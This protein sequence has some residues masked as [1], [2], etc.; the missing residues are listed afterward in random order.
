MYKV[1]FV[2]TISLT[3]K[4][5]VLELAKAMYKTGEFE[6]HFV[7]DYDAEFEKSLPEYIHYRPISMKRGVSL[8]GIKAVCEMIKYFK[9]EKFD[10]VQYST[11]NASCYASLAA[12]IAGIP[13]RLY[14]QWGIVYVGFKGIK[15]K[16]FKLIEKIVCRNSTMIEPDSFGNLHY[17]YKEGLYDESKS[18]VIWNGSACGVDLKK[19]DIS[20]KSEWNQKIREKFSIPQDAVV[21]V[22]VGRITRD[23]GINELFEATKKLMSQKSD[24]YLLL[25]GNMDKSETVDCNLYQWSQ[26]EARVIYCGYTKEVQEYLSAG[27]VYV[28]PSYRE[29]FGMAVIEAESMGVP[30]IVTDIPGVTDAMKKDCTGLVVKKGDSFALYEAMARLYTCKDMRIDMGK[31]AYEFA[32]KNFEQSKL[33]ESIIENRLMLLK[34]KK[35]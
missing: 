8:D 32:S 1:C 28:L 11:P 15:R 6:I 2:T 16:I 13:C 27:D 31:N 24:L 23:K 30:I 29:G 5:F 9:K 26:D 20:Y 3:L 25:V 34:Q 18:C 4:S 33:F 21:Y 10:I 35:Q 19:F 7:C 17:C 14:C 22:F 12:K